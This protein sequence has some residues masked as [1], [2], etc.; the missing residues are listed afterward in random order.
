MVTLASTVINRVLKGFQERGQVDIL[1]GDIDNNQNSLTFLGFLPNWGPGTRIEIGTETILVTA[2]DTTTNTA[3]IVRGWLDTTPVA[4]LANDPI[5][6]NPRLYRSDILEL[7]NEA[8]DDMYGQDLYAFDAQE[9]TYASGQ[10][11]YALDAGA[12]DILRVDAQKDANANYWDPVHDWTEM[13]NA[14]SADFTNGKAIMLRAALP[15]GARFRVVYSKPFVPATS[16][17][18]DLEAVSGIR[19]Y[20]K[21]LPYYYAMHRLMADEERHRSQMEKAENHQRGQDT[22]AFLALRTGQ[23]YQARYEERVRIARAHLMKE[24]K[25]SKASAYGS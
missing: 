14:S 20:M 17:T 2:V 9:L 15:F 21:D 6:V 23:W 1:T 24:A 19:P 11:G 13:D 7:V 10:I 3:T 5:F 25:K 16:E 22:P 8:M 12:V 4:H 18:D